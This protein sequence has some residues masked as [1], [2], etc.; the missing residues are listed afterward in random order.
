MLNGSLLFRFKLDLPHPQWY[1]EQYYRLLFGL[2]GIQYYVTLRIYGDVAIF[3]E[4]RACHTIFTKAL[5]ILFPRVDQRL[6]TKLSQW[7]WLFTAD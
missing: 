7:L 2:S 4:S 6:G 5:R 3:P 1:Y